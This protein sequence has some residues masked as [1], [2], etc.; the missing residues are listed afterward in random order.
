MVLIYNY[1]ADLNIEVRARSIFISGYYIV[2]IIPERSSNL[3]F[4]LIPEFDN[5]FSV[6]QFL[7]DG[8]ILDNQKDIYS[9]TDYI[10]TPLSYSIDP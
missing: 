9:I 7:Y 10:T 2:E 8:E 4:I 5:F 6:N 1:F 3:E